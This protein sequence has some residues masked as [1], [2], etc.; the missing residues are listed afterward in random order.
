MASFILSY[1]IVLI[2]HPI[3]IVFII[4][5]QALIVC[6]AITFS[7]PSAWFSFILFL[8]FMGGLIVL[9][10][11]ISSLA[12]NEKILLFLIWNPKKLI[13]IF[14]IT[15]SII[16][17]FINNQIL[18]NP[19]YIHRNELVFKIYSPNIIFLTL[20]AIIY[21]LLTLIII[22]KITT[23]KEGPLRHIS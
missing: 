21:L 18:S 23:L 22:V 1:L 13:P 4:R 16:L 9:F 10:I 14:I 20:I 19:S 17:I 2:T 8:V 12:S 5:R 7:I 6:L 11:Y 15:F 3:I